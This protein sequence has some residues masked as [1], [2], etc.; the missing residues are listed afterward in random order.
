MSRV[1]ITLTT[2]VGSIFSR[3][4]IRGFFHNFSRGAESGEICFCQLETK[5][6]TF[7]VE[8][9]KIQ[10]GLAPLPHFRRP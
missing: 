2:G 7:F 3:G 1:T 5:K 8:I 6:T 10:S 4:A 9:F